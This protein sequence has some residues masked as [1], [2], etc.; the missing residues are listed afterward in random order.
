MTTLIEYATAL[1]EYFN[2]MLSDN[3]QGNFCKDQFTIGNPPW[4]VTDT[5]RKVSNNPSLEFD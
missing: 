4:C 1:S 5:E 3:G 2:L